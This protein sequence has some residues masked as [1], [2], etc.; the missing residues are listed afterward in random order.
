MAHEPQGLCRQRKIGRMVAI[1]RKSDRPAVT[2]SVTYYYYYYGQTR[3]PMVTQNENPIE[4]RDHR[5]TFEANGMTRDQQ[6]F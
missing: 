2:F 5:R 4:D 6:D 1:R 3:Y